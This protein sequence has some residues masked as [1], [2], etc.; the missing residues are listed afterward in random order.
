MHFWRGFLI[1]ATVSVFL[2]IA[3][4]LVAFTS[5]DLATV[6][7]FFVAPALTY[8]Y[9]VALL[10]PHGGAAAAWLTLLVCVLWC[11][12]FGFF[13]RR[14]DTTDQWILASSAFAGWWIVWRLIGFFTGIHPVLDIRD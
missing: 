9:P 11:A 1:A 14:R 7:G 4:A 5:A 10:M 6:F 3:L 8:A 13:A 12:G 2:P